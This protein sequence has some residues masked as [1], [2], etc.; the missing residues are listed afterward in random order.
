MY[1]ANEGDMVVSLNNRLSH[2]GKQ[3]RGTSFASSLLT[4]P[5]LNILMP[6]IPTS[7]STSRRS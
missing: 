7:A 6:S 1:G 4:C 5:S 2:E 3:S